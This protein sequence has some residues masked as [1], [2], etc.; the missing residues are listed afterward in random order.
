MI[1]TI[2]TPAS[3]L[4]VNDAQLDVLKCDKRCEY[5]IL[6]INIMHIIPKLTLLELFPFVNVKFECMCDCT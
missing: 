4:F 1:A 3:H 2:R 5:S 6:D